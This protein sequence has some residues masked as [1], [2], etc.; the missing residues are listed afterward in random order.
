MTF[1]FKSALTY[2][3]ETPGIIPMK[4][5]IS[6]Y[7]HKAD[8]HNHWKFKVLRKRY[9]WAGEG[10]FWALNNMIA[11]AEGCTL[12]LGDEGKLASIAVDLDFEPT[13]LKEFIQYLLHVSK[14]VFEKDGGITTGIV[15]DIFSEVMDRRISDRKR[16]IPSGVQPE[17]RIFHAESSN[18]HAENQQSK[19]KESKVNKITAITAPPLPP[20]LPK[21]NFLEKFSFDFQKKWQVWR[22]YKKKQHRFSYKSDDTEIAALDELFRKAGNSEAV[23]MEILQQSIAN[24][25]KG[26]FEL[27]NNFNATKNDTSNRATAAQTGNTGQPGRTL[28]AL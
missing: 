20:E 1:F 22:D 3:K 24:G 15:Q 10:K 16:K 23:A 26:F 12:D 27:K 13:G 9:G 7:T 25:W 4:N 5:N 21:N 8:S 6:Y 18:F 19:V 28:A 2:T 17:K 14:L 11:D